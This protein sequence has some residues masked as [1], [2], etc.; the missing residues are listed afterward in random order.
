[1]L[2]KEQLN[3]TSSLVYETYFQTSEDESTC[4]DGSVIYLDAHG[5]KVNGHELDIVTLG[6]TS[7]ATY[8]DEIIDIATQWKTGSVTVYETYILAVP[9]VALTWEILQAALAR[10]FENVYGVSLEQARIRLDL[11]QIQATMNCAEMSHTREV[12]NYGA[13]EQ[14]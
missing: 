13:F 9:T 3:N 6:D 11:S 14:V 8:V 2:T 1:M 12:L 7:S 5:H 10:W 4:L